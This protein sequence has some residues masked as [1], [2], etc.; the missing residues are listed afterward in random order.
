[1]LY[2]CTMSVELPFRETWQ[3]YYLQENGPFWL[4]RCC[5]LLIMI[6][7]PFTGSVDLSTK[8]T[9]WD[10]LI[11]CHSTFQVRV[12]VSLLLSPR[13]SINMTCNIYVSSKPLYVS[14]LKKRQKYSEYKVDEGIRQCAKNGKIIPFNSKA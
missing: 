3:A 12:R 6:K 7:N 10:G 11:I 13:N 14:W 5:L 8:I 2:F 1:M 9:N 4:E